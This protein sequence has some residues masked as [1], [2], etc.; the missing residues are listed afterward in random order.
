[1]SSKRSKFAT[2][3]CL[4]TAPVAGCVIAEGEVGQ[5][6]EDQELLAAAR[7]ISLRVVPETGLGAGSLHLGFVAYQDGDGAWR[8]MTGAD[9][10]YKARV[11]N[12]RYGVAVG[13]TRAQYPGVEQAWS[14][15]SIQYS[16]VQEKTSLT[17][18]ACYSAVPVP[19]HVV[20]GTATGLL[21]GE[22]A[23]IQSGFFVSAPV[24]A[25]GAFSFTAPAGSAPILGMSY[26]TNALLPSRV[27]R[28]PNVDTTTDPVISVDFTNAVA[29][30]V[31]P[32]MTPAGE[33]P[34]VTSVVRNGLETFFG[35]MRA[36]S[37]TSYSAVPASLLRQGDLIRVSASFA[38]ETT[39]RS[40][41]TYFAQPSPATIET[42][43]AFTATVTD[44]TSGN[45]RPS[46]SFAHNR[47][48][49]AIG[50]YY[51]DASTWGDTFYTSAA[52]N[53]SRDWLGR[54]RQVAYQLPDFSAMAGWSADMALL[55]GELSW[56]AQRSEQTT[57]DFVPGRKSYTSSSYGYI[58]ADA[59]A[60]TATPRPR[61]HVVPAE[62]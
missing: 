9:G 59:P 23:V 36:P 46:F 18:L 10:V 60:L 7:E 27:M 37:A 13:C 57:E 17:D 20:S 50:S 62:L 58:P 11:R 24:D 4:A 19:E 43:P 52:V 1:M 53:M 35:R 15:V 32:M 21:P 8:K 44:S 33:A 54:S 38:D 51:L 6:G 42:P 45:R 40:F 56:T 34:Y 61:A 5:G 30:S 29:P 12:R 28:A 3:L 39:T 16:T 2:V 49:L 41:I 25:A 14:G 22:Q 48:T 26:A 55:P 47:G 31:Q